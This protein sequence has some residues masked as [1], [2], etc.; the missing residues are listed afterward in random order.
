MSC[1]SFSHLFE[2]FYTPFF[3]R[4]QAEALVEQLRMA[5]GRGV[6]TDG[7]VKKKPGI[8]SICSGDFG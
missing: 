3:D 2:G 7:L 8:Y 4:S 6:F 5:V 1:L